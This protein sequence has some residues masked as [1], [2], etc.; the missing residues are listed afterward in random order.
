MGRAAANSIA[1]KARSRPYHGRC[2]LLAPAKGQPQHS[3]GETTVLPARSSA[4]RARPPPPAPAGKSS[5]ALTRS[6]VPEYQHEQKQDDAR[7]NS[8]AE[9]NSLVDK[10][11]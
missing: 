11:I 1:C 3:V 9:Q 6:S 2:L 5:Y 8:D 7:E 10:T 4:S